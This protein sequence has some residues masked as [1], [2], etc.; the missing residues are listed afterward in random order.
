MYYKIKSKSLPM[1]NNPK[2]NQLTEKADRL[3]I[4][5][6]IIE[7]RK[8]LKRD[9]PERTV[10]ETFLLATWNIRDFGAYGGKHFNPS[11]RLTES[12]FYI[13]EI[14]SA[15]DLV[16]MQEVNENMSEFIKLM[17]IL[18][19]NWRYIATDTTE[20]S[21][22]N[23]ERMAFI[24][25]TSKVFFQ[26]IAG[27]IVL[28]ERTKKKDEKDDKQFARTPFL[29]KFQIGWLKFNLCTVHLYYGEDKGEKL[30]RRVKE[31]DNIAGFIHKRCEKD[32]ENY[33]LLGDMN[34]VS[35]TDATMAAL[36]KH[37]FILPSDITKKHIPSNM[38]Q[39][40]LYD[41][42]AFL[43]KD[44]MVELGKSEN[45]A[46]VFNYYQTIFREKD[47]D[48]YYKIATNKDE[49]NKQDKFIWGENETER[50]KYFKSDWRTWQM[51]DHLP[52]WV[53]LKIDFTD[54]FLEKLKEEV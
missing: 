20:G 34:I 48:I 54:K 19:P 46:G 37:D 44:E 22:G 30:D 53:E 31:I 11:P 28:P 23:G 18:G 41:Q 29:V 52:M 49:K 25:D 26:N 33:I 9:I 40:K 8:H 1:Y 35:A 27:E 42:I 39:D 5:E 51:S 3:R 4:I 32:N 17:E 45:N 43:Y 47:F 6:N 24:Y 12:L 14:I 50:K 2:F 7:L 15:Y 36:K 38:N 16:A 21:G 10:G 13:A